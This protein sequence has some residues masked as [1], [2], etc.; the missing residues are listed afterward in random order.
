MKLITD[1]WTKEK[2]EFKEIF[3][4]NNKTQDVLF[5]T[6]LNN[7]TQTVAFFKNLAKKLK[8]LNFLRDEMVDHYQFAVM[9]N[10]ELTPI[11]WFDIQINDN[12]KISHDIAFDTTLIRKNGLLIP[13][14]KFPM[15][16]YQIKPNWKPSLYRK[17][18]MQANAFKYIANLILKN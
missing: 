5:K 15:Y 7:P 2:F 4:Y 11:K 6:D 16:M 9:N 1:F 17:Q 12:L 14:G 18:K 8:S 3:F 10:G 13:F